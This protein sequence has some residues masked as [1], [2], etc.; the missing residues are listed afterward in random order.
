MTYKTEKNLLVVLGPNASGKTSLGVQLAN[1]IEAE[2]IS[3]DSR[4]VY[5]GLDIGSGKDLS[6][7][8]TAGKKIP[9]NLIDVVDLDYEY[10]VFDFQSRF[11]EIFNSLTEN[12]T[13][14]ILVGG[15]GLYLE[16]VLLHYPLVEAPED[17]ALRKELADKSY[18][19][20][21]ERLA[22]LKSKLHTSQQRS[23]E[24]L[25]RFI[26][27]EV[28]SKDHSPPP[29]P[30][31]QP[32]VLGIHWEKD[33][34]QK[35]IRNRLEKRFQQGMIDEVQNLI[36]RGVPPDKLRRLG[37]EYR[38]IVEYLQKE[39]TSYQDLVE[40]LFIAIRQFA[41]RQRSWFRRMEKRGI[42]IHWLE[43]ANQEQAK[44]IISSY[45]L[46]H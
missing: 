13:L 39:I 18:S 25:I 14:P 32:L 43:G 33:V 28:Y 35:R 5:R 40:K 11:Y 26:E 17:P 9:Y 27:I 6:E 37:L 36:N 8:I 45:D 38:F 2:I 46:I 15:T 41:K 12:N 21:V 44:K 24:K 29:P 19:E 1:E 23:K 42:E 3:A 16:S 31:I 30:D 20:L 4:Q 7:Y 10:S 22:Q 34:L